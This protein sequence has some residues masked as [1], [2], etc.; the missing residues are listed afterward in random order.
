MRKVNDIRFIG[1]KVHGRNDLTDKVYILYSLGFKVNYRGVKDS[2]LSL[3]RYFLKNYSDGSDHLFVDIFRNEICFGYYNECEDL[4]VNI[5]D[6]R[7]CKDIYDK[8]KINNSF[9]NNR[10]HYSEF[11]ERCLVIENMGL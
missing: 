9:L 10:E 1:V 7:E 2:Y 6:F 8:S 3:L 11:I 5:G 4:I